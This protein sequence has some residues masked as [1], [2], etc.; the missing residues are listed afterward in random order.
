MNNEESRKKPEPPKPE[1]F[2]TELT[3]E[4]EQYVI[5]GTEHK[6]KPGEQGRLF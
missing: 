3:P 4:G 1:E 5:P 2:N 6:P